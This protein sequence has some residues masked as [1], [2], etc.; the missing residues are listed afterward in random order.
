MTDAL[1]ASDGLVE[2][3]ASDV[4]GDD[5]LV[6]NKP[7]YVAGEHCVDVGLVSDGAG[8]EQYLLGVVTPEDGW[9]AV[10]EV[11]SATLEFLEASD[12]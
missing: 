2:P 12:G 5:A 8:S 1:L 11:A 3:A 9:S 7:G 10:V 6:Y 4:L